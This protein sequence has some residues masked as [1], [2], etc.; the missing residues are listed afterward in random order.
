M[1]DIFRAAAQDQKLN[2]KADYWNEMKANLDDA[3]LDDAFRYAADKFMVTAPAD[4]SNSLDDALL[5]GTFHNAASNQNLTYSAAAWTEFLQQEEILFQDEAFLAASNLITAD[6]HPAYWTEADTALQNEGLH[7]EYKSEYWD[8]AR[9]LLDKGDRSVF[10]YRWASVAA[11]LLLISGGA[12]FFVNDSHVGF[13]RNQNHHQ[14]LNR[15][16]HQTN[17]NNQTLTVSNNNTESESNNH[18]IE[19]NYTDQLNH[20]FKHN[21]DNEKLSNGDLT[22]PGDNHSVNGSDMPDHGTG[23][24]DDSDNAIAGGQPV[25]DINNE[26]NQVE[27]SE[28]VHEIF[29]SD[30]TSTPTKFSAA[31]INK[32]QREDD[33]FN[34]PLIEIE[35]YTNLPDHS[36][37]FI[38]QAGLG[39]KYGEYE[40]TPSWRT[41]V[42]FEY[43][44]TSHDR[45]R[46]FEFGGQFS[47]NHVRQNDFGTERRVTVFN[48]TGGV[49]KFWYKL[50]L[51]DMIYANTSLVM[52]YKIDRRQNLRFTL[53][54]DYLVFVQS[55]MSY[56]NEPDAGITTVNN[57]WGVKDGIK[58]FDLR[59][60]IGYEFELNQRFALQ[61]NGSAG[62]FDR[63]D[64]EF[65]HDEFK[66]REMNVT[67]GI[68]YTFVNCIR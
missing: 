49:D 65:I 36:V 15:N 7:F 61:L 55:N 18:R 20:E 30:F 46:N 16:Y 23:I 32:I 50:Q 58:K 4:V 26:H 3:A 52:S 24:S 39:N 33:A 31:T 64:D 37:S 44:R 40:L 6:Y 54:A 29:T 51:K 27:N 22:L 9:I 45:F 53:G 57:N 12:F 38:G 28:N 42:G 21:S 1:D 66:D 43:K 41:S 67:L 11:I 2:Y 5:D 62:L 14:E 60:G 48:H 17:L 8:Q 19:Q 34:V 47:F 59:M 10:F 25:I 68:K 63:S 35:K 56:Q 13:A